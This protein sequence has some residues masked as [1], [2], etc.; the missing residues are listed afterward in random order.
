[1]ECV[2][3][4]EPTDHTYQGT[5]ICPG[6]ARLAAAMFDAAVLMVLR[7]MPE[8][9]LGPCPECGHDRT[10]QRRPRHRR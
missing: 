4:N 2:R 1:M 5:P 8:A 6:C 9:L 10:R 7:D 3:C